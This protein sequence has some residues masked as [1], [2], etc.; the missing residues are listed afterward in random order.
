MLK[1]NKNV[2]FFTIY[3]P[4][5]YIYILFHWRNEKEI[6]ERQKREYR[7][8][9]RKTRDLVHKLI[10]VYVNQIKKKIARQKKIGSGFKG[11][12]SHFITFLN[13]KFE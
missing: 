11:D 4:I 8:H 9:P 13:E 2:T 10:V 7:T 5:K 3:D 1:L 6:W 12:C